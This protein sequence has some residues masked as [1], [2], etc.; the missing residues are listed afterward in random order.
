MN[1]IQLKLIGHKK[2]VFNKHS[3]TYLMQIKL[4][5]FNVYEIGVIAMLR[6]KMAFL[7]DLLPLLEHCILTQSEA[8]VY[9]ALD[10]SLKCVIHVKLLFQKSCVLNRQP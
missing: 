2:Y 7:K 10:F 8:L 4:V 3:E 6:A 1:V 5:E 9:E